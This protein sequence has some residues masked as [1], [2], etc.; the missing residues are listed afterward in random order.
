MHDRTK[1]GRRNWSS[2]GAVL[3]R[4]RRV[5]SPRRGPVVNR[6]SDGRLR[7]DTEQTRGPD[8]RTRQRPGGVFSRIRRWLEDRDPSAI[9]LC[10]GFLLCCPRRRPGAGRRILP[11][12]RRP[13]LAFWLSLPQC[14]GFFPHKNSALSTRAHSANHRHYRRGDELPP[15][16]PPQNRDALPEYRL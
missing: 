14:A 4:R 8:G 7:R 9:G 12:E 5:A 13:F 11:A 16:R 2:L 15:R 3:G 1:E 10:L 6:V